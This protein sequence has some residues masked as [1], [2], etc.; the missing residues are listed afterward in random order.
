MSDM[1]DFLTEHWRLAFIACAMQPEIG[2]TS[3]KL[4][5]RYSKTMNNNNNS[6]GS[7]SIRAIDHATR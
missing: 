2:E 5:L 4:F 6:K 1:K 3:V 7:H